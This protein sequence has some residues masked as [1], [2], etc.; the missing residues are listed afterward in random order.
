MRRTIPA[1]ALALVACTAPSP[2]ATP[3]S[4]APTKPVAGVQL[5]QWPWAS[6]GKEC[7]DFLGPNDYDFVVLSP[8]QEHITGP[9]WWTSYQPVSYK[10]ASKLGTRDEFKAM[11]ESCH[12]AGVKVYADAV[13]N[14]MAGV[15]KGTGFAGTVFSHYEYPGLYTYDDFHHCAAVGGDIANYQDRA[16]VQ[17]CEL[18]N[19]ADLRTD[20]ASV[21]E[22]ITAYLKDLQGLGVD[23]F[24]IDAGKHMPAADIEA[25]VKE[26]DGDPQ[27]ISEVIRASGEPIQPEEYLGSG[28]VFAFQA[29]T[30]LTGIV[31]GGSLEKV[32]DLADGEVSS[33]RAY[34]FVANHDTERNGRTLTY[35]DGERYS[36]ATSLLLGIDYGTPVVYSGYAFTDK[37]AGPAATNGRV[38]DVTCTEGDTQ[39]GRW[40][41]QHRAAAGMAQWRAVVGDAGVSNAF[42]D[43]YNVAFDR[44]RLGLLAANAG[45]EPWTVELT[46]GLPDGAYC[47]AITGG[48]CTADKAIAVKDGKVTVTVPVNGAIALHVNRRA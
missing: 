10:V 46:T 37:D 4:E 27:I 6:V 40:L 47:D 7:G 41:C 19:L 14:H 25:I 48:D 15:E 26:L 12:D 36:L 17:T 22:K 16:E 33:A 21:R 13:I 30:D 5:F 23:G 2:P 32:L 34:T 9:Q 18:S 3:P 44:G 42:S 8:A 38:N 39:P 31:R 24:R 1:L 20:L 43:G 28:D 29:A 11:V 45:S 35:K